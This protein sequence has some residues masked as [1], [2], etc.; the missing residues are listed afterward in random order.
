LEHPVYM[1]V[2]RK[3]RKRLSSSFRRDLINVLRARGRIAKLFI[4][5]TPKGERKFAQCE[6]ISLALRTSQIL[7]GEPSSVRCWE[8]NRRRQEDRERRTRW[9][10]KRMETHKGKVNFLVSSNF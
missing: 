4:S 10:W 2:R 1:H 7:D 8:Q 6:T 9:P 5:Y 3:I